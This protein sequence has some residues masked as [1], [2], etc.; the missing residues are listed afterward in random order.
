ML[1][2]VIQNATWIPKVFAPERCLTKLF[3]IL[4]PLHVSERSSKGVMG[5]FAIV[6]KSVYLVFSTGAAFPSD[7]ERHLTQKGSDFLL[8]P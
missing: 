5:K 2:K 8:S 4:L 3:W 7:F 6:V 1:P